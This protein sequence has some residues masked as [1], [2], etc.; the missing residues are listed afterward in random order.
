MKIIAVEQCEECPFATAMA[1]LTDKETMWCIHG[2]RPEPK[3]LEGNVMDVPD[4]CPLEDDNENPI[5]Q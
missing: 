3:K 1:A 4:D 5:L 2:E